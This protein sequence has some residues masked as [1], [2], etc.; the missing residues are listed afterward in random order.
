MQEFKNDALKGQ[1]TFPETMVEA[2]AMLN[3]Y[4]ATASTLRDTYGY[5]QVDFAQKEDAV[6]NTYKKETD[7]VSLAQKGHKNKYRS[8]VTCC[9]C[10]KKAH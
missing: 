1:S 2:S 8:G 5:E 10:Q 7:G 4:S 6:P 3:N 9:H